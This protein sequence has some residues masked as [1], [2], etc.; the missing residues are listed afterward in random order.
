MRFLGASHHAILH[1]KMTA[2]QKDNIFLFNI[3]SRWIFKILGEHN[4][5]DSRNDII[6]GNEL[7]TYFITDKTRTGSY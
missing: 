5:S 2:N 4:P 1:V 7:S 6:K 3:V